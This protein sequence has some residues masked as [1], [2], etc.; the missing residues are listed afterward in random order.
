MKPSRF[1]L[2]LLF[3]LSMAACGSKPPSDELLR[4]RQAY[5]QAESSETRELAPDR[6]LTARQALERAE[7]EHKD[8][9]ASVEEQ[10]RAYIAE[11][12]AYLAS[13]WAAIRAAT[14][15][16]EKAKREYLGELELRQ[17]TANRQLENTR[18]NLIQAQDLLNKEREARLEAEAKAAAA[19]QRL[20]EIAKVQEENRGTVVTLQS[21]SLFSGRK[22][23]LLP[24]ARD[25]LSRLSAVLLEKGKGKTIVIAV[26]TDSR[27]S[28]VS[29]LRLS[30]RRADAVRGVLMSLGVPGASIRSR[31]VGEAE[32]IADNR[33]SAGRNQNQRVEIVIGGQ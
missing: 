27:G 24:G 10:T 33:T 7:A 5:T 29:N 2:C 21:A 25:Q 30:Q 32:P 13:A 18:S 3:A 15:A 6:L 28:E 14:T 22:A 16:S 19:M 20:E 12:K 4:A 31:G 9:P 1:F 11:R 8:D 17:R 26:H 23:T